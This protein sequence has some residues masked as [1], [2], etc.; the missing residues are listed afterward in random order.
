MVSEQAGSRPEPD[1]KKK[2]KKEQIKNAMRSLAERL[3]PLMED[4]LFNLW[5]TQGKREGQYIHPLSWGK[6]AEQGLGGKGGGVGWKL[7]ELLTARAFVF[8]IPSQL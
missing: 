6:M 7:D 2:K 5:A 8:K 1:N 3:Q 4:A